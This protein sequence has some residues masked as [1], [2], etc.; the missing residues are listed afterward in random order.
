[1]RPP[2]PIKDLPLGPFRLDGLLGSGGMGNVYSATHGHSGLEVAVKVLRAHADGGDDASRALFRNE[3]E[4]HARLQHPSVVMVLDIGYVPPEVAAKAPAFL[5]PGAPFIAMEKADGGSLYDVMTSLDWTQIKQLLL[6][7]LDALAHAHARG[8]IHRDLKPGNILLCTEAS[9][10]PGL[11]LTDFGIAHAIASAG[12]EGTREAAL[13]TP[14]YMSPEQFEGRWR[15]YGPW[16]DLYA[17]GVV[18]WELIC[19]TRPIHGTTDPD[20]IE[21]ALSLAYAH[22]GNPLPPLTPRM[23]TPPGLESW[24]GR[25]LAK[26]TADRFRWA[27]DAAWAL[28]QLGDPAPPRRHTGERPQLLTFSHQENSGWTQPG[29][30]ASQHTLDPWADAVESRAVQL[31][32]PFPA[33]WQRGDGEPPWQLLD[34]GLNL[35]GLRPVRFVGRAEERETIW[36]A[37]R[38]VREEGRARALLVR[39][40][41]GI[42]KTRLVD[43]MAAR[44]HEVGAATVLRATHGPTA[45]GDG[46]RGMVARLL[47]CLGLGR[48]QVRERVEARLRSLGVTDPYEWRALTELLSPSGEGSQNL[49]GGMTVSSAQQR[50][51][52]IGRLLVALGRERPVVMVLDDVHWGLDA[53]NFAA[54]MMSAQAFFP[55]R[56][57]FLLASQDGLPEDIPEVAALRGLLARD[58]A[59]SMGLGPLEGVERSELVGELLHLEGELAQAVEART[60]GHPLFAVQLV[61]DWVQ[62]GLLTPGSGGFELSLGRPDLPADIYEM[63]TSAMTRLVGEDP[64]TQVS[65]EIAAVLGVEVLDAEWLF[66]CDE[67]GV[68]TADNALGRLAERGLAARTDA[69]WTFLTAMSRDWLIREA[70][71]AGRLAGHHRICASMLRHLYAHAPEGVAERIADHA[72][73]AGEGGIA[74]A[75]LMRAAI[76]RAERSEYANA[77]RLLDRREAVLLD[78]GRDEDDEEICRGRVLRAT[79]QIEDGNVVE[80]R[81][82]AQVA[83]SHA[84]DHDDAL[85]CRALMALGR[86]TFRA[87]D[88]ADAAS[89][90][91][92]AMELAEALGDDPAVAEC[93]RHCGHVAHLRRDSDA[94]EAYYEEAL[95]I[96]TE[97]DDALGMGQCLRSLG[98]LYRQRGQMPK[99]RTLYEEAAIQL[100]A[101]GN[102]IELARLHN[103]LGEIYRFEGDLDSAE[104][105]YR[106]ALRLH[107]EC[108][109]A[110][111]VVARLNLGLV[112]LGRGAYVESRT[113]LDS[114]LATLRQLGLATLQP[115][116]HAGLLACCAAAGDPDAWDEHLTGADTEVCDTDIASCAELA[117]D[118][119]AE[120]DPVRARRAYELAMAQWRAINRSD[121]ALGVERTLASLP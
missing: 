41:A 111:S 4:N 98:A 70:Q 15:D 2:L 44:A 45:G 88:H 65:L 50:Y 31:H 113:V 54:W 77:M 73:G 112:Q 93:L 78:L 81:R 36:E 6:S 20:G 23:R 52:V 90:Y 80:A 56:C 57:L 118:L 19:H 119:L 92:E 21:T 32:P 26:S 97:I 69:G 10:R 40:P 86:A 8:V 85:L 17:L 39:G 89:L 72:L 96:S 100:D 104:T 106:L 28:D 116:V 51:A 75:P 11:K 68:P 82:T 58:G 74:V 48:P 29:L 84:R 24:L 83:V 30:L 43:W 59:G 108:G 67:A 55:T 63:W 79:I 107:E 102:R 117:G 3:I 47:R 1:M 22:I 64:R 62:R 60:A 87:G 101:A 114:G 109:S 76:W 61:G 16:T 34:A 49:A 121:R 103:G 25:L 71:N 94:E 14:Q 33:D 13:G 105:S 27:A 46:L 95:A 37:I 7:L 42:G 38:F 18:A 120:A 99:A 5:S 115:Y 9:P 66:A 35:Y 91:Q 53:I 12:G 110:E